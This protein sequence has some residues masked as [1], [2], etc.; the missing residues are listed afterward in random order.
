[1]ACSDITWD[2]ILKDS[3]HIWYCENLKSLT[4]VN[5]SVFLSSA[6]AFPDKSNFMLKSL[7]CSRSLLQSETAVCAL[8]LNKEQWLFCVQLFFSPFHKDQ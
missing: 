5:V 3:I 8:C 7:K 1:M 2:H 4:G 6:T